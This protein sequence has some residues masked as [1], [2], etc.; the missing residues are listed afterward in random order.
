MSPGNTRSL[1]QHSLAAAEGGG[2]NLTP[3][4]PYRL[5]LYVLSKLHKE[6]GDCA[7]MSTLRNQNADSTATH[8]YIHRAQYDATSLTS[9]AS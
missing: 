8:T 1:L 4:C 5:P 6:W 9:L 2:S 3:W 7:K